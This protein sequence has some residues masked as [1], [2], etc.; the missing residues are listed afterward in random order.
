M[1]ETFPICV[2]HFLSAMDQWNNEQSYDLPTGARVLALLVTDELALPGK[3][4]GTADSKC[5]L[6][7]DIMTENFTT[8]QKVTDKIMTNFFKIRQI[9]SVELIGIFQPPLIYLPCFCGVRVTWRKQS[10]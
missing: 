8:A 10:P 3:C 4:A 5:T 1:R 9:S 6:A 2:K 7:A